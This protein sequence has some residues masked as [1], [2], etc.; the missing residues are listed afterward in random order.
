MH[1]FNYFY[2]RYIDTTRS[3]LCLNP[4]RNLNR[5]PLPLRARHP[6]SIPGTPRPAS[7]Q[8]SPLPRSP[9]LFDD[10][11]PPRR[12]DAGCACLFFR[13]GFSSRLCALGFIFQQAGG[14]AFGDHA[15]FARVGGIGGFVLREGDEVRVGDAAVGWFEDGGLVAFF[16]G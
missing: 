3:C 8:P 15:A 12:L 9:D 5:P 14:V 7:I 2:T 13:C 6:I 16:T 10:E 4:R 11:L 1:S